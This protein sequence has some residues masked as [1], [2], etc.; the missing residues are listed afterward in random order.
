[1]KIGP[2][3]VILYDRVGH[4][5]RR[6]KMP[7]PKSFASIMLAVTTRPVAVASRPRPNN[8][9]VPLTVQFSSAGHLRPPDTKRRHLLRLEL[10]SATAPP[11]PPRLIPYSLTT[12]RATSR[13]SSRSMTITANVTVANVSVAAGNNNKPVVTISQPPNGRNL[14]LGQIAF[15]TQSVSRISPKTAA[16]VA[17]TI[18]CLQYRDRP[19]ARSQ[20]IIPMAR[21]SSNACSGI[22]TTPLSTDSDF[23]QSLLRSLTPPTPTR[24]RAPMSLPS[25]LL[26]HTFSSHAHKQS[27]VLHP[28]ARR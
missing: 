12:A 16:L 6:R 23:R 15:P 1:M 5:F 24:G 13:R 2:D 10:L 7:T 19:F 4:R 21:A 27:R 22:F 18:A 17:A 26:P 8:G 25:L 20:T 28:L 9:S 11:T 3:G 14:R